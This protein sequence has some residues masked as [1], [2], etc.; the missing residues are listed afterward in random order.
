[1]A[2]ERRQTRD[3]VR[4][5]PKSETAEGQARGVRGRGAARVADGGGRRCVRCAVCGGAMERVAAPRHGQ[6]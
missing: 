5:S 3:D 1:V 6:S 4:D 2:R